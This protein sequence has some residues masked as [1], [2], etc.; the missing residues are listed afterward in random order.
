MQYI[1]LKIFINF[2]G[3]CGWGG[4]KWLVSRLLGGL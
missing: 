3:F 2:L 1:E 4:G